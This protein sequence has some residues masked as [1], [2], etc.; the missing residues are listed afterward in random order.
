MEGQK[1]REKSKFLILTMY[2]LGL[3]SFVQS[4]HALSVLTEEDISPP[5]YLQL[6]LNDG[7]LFY[8]TGTVCEQFAQQ[9]S[10]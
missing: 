3:N 10:N 2:W 9:S 4:S 8:P 6:I 5:V 7:S 1:A